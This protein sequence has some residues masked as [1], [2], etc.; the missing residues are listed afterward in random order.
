M[1]LNISTN[2]H[3]T[4]GFNLSVDLS[5]ATDRVTALYGTSGS[6][7]TTLLRLITGLDREAGVKVNFNGKAWQTADFFLPVHKRRVGFVFQNLNLFPHLSTAGNLNFAT[8]RNNSNEG[9]SQNEVIDILDIGNLLSKHPGNL[10]GGEQ[11]RVAIAR[12]LLSNP[13]LLVMDEPL[14]S[15][16]TLAKTRILPYLQRLHSKLK[17]PVVYVSHSLDEVLELSDEVILLE[18]GQATTKQSVFDFAVTGPDADLPHGTAMIRCH[19]T[20]KDPDNGLIVLSFEKQT[21]YIATSSY[22]V[23]DPLRIR[24][25]SRDVSLAT[26]KPQASSILNVLEGNI[27]EIHADVAGPTVVVIVRCGEQQVLAQITRKSLLD[28]GLRIGQ[29]VYAQGKGVALMVNDDR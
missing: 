28:M 26:K 19:V 2:L 17:I 7:K 13:E 15:I 21:M 18:S 16:D 14:G 10:S 22:S 6:G 20:G 4:G 23:G 24:I 27:Q 11:Q 25:P 9:L 8:R 12:A 3:R 29:R 5:I 1:S